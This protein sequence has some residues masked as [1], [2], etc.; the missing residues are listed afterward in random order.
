[1]AIERHAA[2]IEPFGAEDQPGEFAASGTDQTTYSENLAA[3]Q[4]ET[5]VVNHRQRSDATDGQHDIHGFSLL[6]ATFE[7]VDL[8][9]NDRFDEAAV[10][11]IGPFESGH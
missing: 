9:A 2:G 6:M 4:I 8:S 7:P 10:G 11:E 3:M 5:D 1:M